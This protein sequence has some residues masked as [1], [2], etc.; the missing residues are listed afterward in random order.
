LLK[1][2]MLVLAV[3]ALLVAAAVPAFAAKKD[4][5]KAQKQALLQGQAV[6]AAQLQG[7][8]DTGPAT[9]TY[10]PVTSSADFNIQDATGGDQFAGSGAGGFFSGGD[11]QNNASTQQAQQ[12]T[13]ENASQ[14]TGANSGNVGQQQSNNLG[15]QSG[16][17]N[18]D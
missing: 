2:V 17:Q 4:G 11:E 16:Q 13:N 15:Q 3:I 14:A 9:N 1:K 8:N 10:S 5:K 6:G 7:A 12:N 18:Q